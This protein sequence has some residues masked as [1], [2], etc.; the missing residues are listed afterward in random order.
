M[1]YAQAIPSLSQAQ[2]MKKMQQAGLCTK[3]ALCAIMSEEKKSDLDRVTIKND[4]LKKY[5]P[6]S[7][8]PKQMEDTIIKLLEQWQRKQNHKQEL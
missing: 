2:R 6:K 8:T 7:Y 3:E 5:F 4:V 1:D